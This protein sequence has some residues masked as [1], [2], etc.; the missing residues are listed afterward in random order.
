MISISAIA[1]VL[2]DEDRTPLYAIDLSDQDETLPQTSTDPQVETVDWCFE[3]EEI[4]FDITALR[5][6]LQTLRHDAEIYKLG[7]C[8]HHI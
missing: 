8:L 3:F 7:H 2:V 6:K 5:S 1:S 4:E